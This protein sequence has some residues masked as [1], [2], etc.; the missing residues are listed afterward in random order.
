MS[1]NPTNERA[2]EAPRQRTLSLFDRGKRGRARKAP[3]VFR[4]FRVFRGS[5]PGRRPLR[6]PFRTTAFVGFVDEF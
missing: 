3:V 5:N 1:T 4:D 2:S 6:G